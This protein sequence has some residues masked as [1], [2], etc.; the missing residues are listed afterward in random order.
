MEETSGDLLPSPYM[1]A[2]LS[3]PVFVSKVHPGHGGNYLTGCMIRV[4]GVMYTSPT[5]SVKGPLT[6]DK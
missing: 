2:R 6:E 1:F 3:L 5:P 4:K